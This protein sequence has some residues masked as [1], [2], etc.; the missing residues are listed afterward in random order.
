MST[1]GMGFGLMELLIILTMGAG[2]G[3]P[4]GIPPGDPDPLLENIAPES[5]IYYTNWAGMAEPDAKSSNQTEQLLAEPEVQQFAA[6]VESLIRSGLATASRRERDPMLQLAADHAPDLIKTLITHPT[7]IF[8]ERLVPKGREMDVSGALVVNVGDDLPAVRRAIA[9]LTAAIPAEGIQS[10]TVAGVEV[11]SVKPDPSAPLISWAFR[12]SHFILAVGDDAIAGIVRRAETPAPK[13]L[14]GAKQSLEVGR[15]STMAYLNLAAIIRTARAGGGAEAERIIDVLGVGSLETMVSVTGMD[16]NGCVS[17]SRVA[18][19][20]KKGGILKLA[21]HGKLTADDV[22]V[23]PQDALVAGAASVNVKEIWQGILDMT[24]KIEPRAAEEM[25]QGVRQMEEGL[26]IRLVDDLLGPLGDVWTIHTARSSGGLMAGWTATVSLA[27]K[28]RF[29][30]THDQLLGFIKGMAARERRAPQFGSFT[31]RGQLVH[32]LQIPQ[33]G[34]PFSPSWCI[35]DDHLVVTLLP[36]AM[37][38]F[39]N[40]EPGDKS[41]VDQPQVADAFAGETTPCAFL[42]E[43]TRAQFE[44]FYPMVQ[45]WLPMMAGQMQREGINVDLSILPS[46]SSIAPHLRPSLTVFSAGDGELTSIS[47]RTLPGASVG[48]STPILVA[49]LLP[50]VQSARAA[51]RRMQSSNNIKQIVLAMHNY[52]NVYRAFPPAHGVDA[53]GKPLLSWRVYVLPYLEQQGLYEEFHFDEPWDSPHNKTL[54]P[55]MP[56]VY[57][58]PSTQLQ[59]GKTTYLAN[60]SEGGALTAPEKEKGQGKSPRGIR[61]RD[62]RDGTSN[63]ILTV[64]AAASEAVIWTKPGDFSADKNNP[65][66]GLLGVYPGGF[67]AGMC[68]GSV[69]FISQSLDKKTWKALLTRDGGEVVQRGF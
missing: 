46:S 37:K 62:F 67:L 57:R 65:F 40:R 61:I 53:N 29:Q 13:W 32:N 49:L 69:R 31:Y 66:K 1:T 42:F 41:I 45:V 10:G 30:R 20:G 15:P 2:A 64:E 22:Q 35:T 58:S 59:P 26:G 54:I 6:G 3:V 17:R 23:I 36:Q 47:H 33:F 11:H 34:F 39:L 38:T 25:V 18:Y 24:A 63:T 51:A 7:A 21:G 4:M 55:R 5:C 9:A 43:D 16:D 68:D 28:G 56:A 12:G 50:A 19:S 27:D 60:A 52:H 48:A 14:T 8:V 44:T